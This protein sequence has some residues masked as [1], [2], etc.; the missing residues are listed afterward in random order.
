MC[1]EDV[2]LGRRKE[3]VARYSAANTTT[4][5]QVMGPNPNRAAVVVTVQPNSATVFDMGVAIRSG[6]AGGPLLARL[7]TYD[8]TWYGSV[9]HYG[10]GVLRSIWV[11]GFSTD[12]EAVDATEIRWNDELRD[13]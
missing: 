8:R 5:A 11:V 6:A 1:K 13:I 12:G 4:P 7:S 2:R 9:E 10:D 3:A